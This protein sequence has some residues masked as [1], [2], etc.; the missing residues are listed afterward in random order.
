VVLRPLLLWLP[1][2]PHQLLHLAADWGLLL[3]QHPLPVFQQ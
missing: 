2:L 3:L 1:L